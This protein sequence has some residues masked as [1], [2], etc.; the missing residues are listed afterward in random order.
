MTSRAPAAAGAF[1]LRAFSFPAAGIV[2]RAEA[3]EVSGERDRLGGRGGA[4]DRAAAGR[5]RSGEREGAERRDARGGTR[6]ARSRVWRR[7]VKTFVPSSHHD[8]QRFSETGENS[9]LFGEEIPVSKKLEID[10]LKPSL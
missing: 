9:P 10:G 8:T 3:R 6:G 7:V 1:L 4:T 5:S 2:A